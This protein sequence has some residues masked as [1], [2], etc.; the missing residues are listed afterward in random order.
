MKVVVFLR[1]TRTSLPPFYRQHRLTEYI[2]GKPS[3]LGCSDIRFCDG[4]EVAL[5]CALYPP[6][7]RSNEPREVGA[8]TAFSDYGTGPAGGC[9]C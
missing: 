3:M 8:S 7:L 9:D 4:N 6:N 1:Q 2:L 5:Q